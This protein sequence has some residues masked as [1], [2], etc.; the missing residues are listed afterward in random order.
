MDDGTTRGKCPTNPSN[1]FCHSNG[2]CNVCRLDTSSGVNVGCETLSSTPVCDADSTTTIVDD[3][4]LE[5][6]AACV[7]CKQDGKFYISTILDIP[8]HFIAHPANRNTGIL[9][10]S[11][12]VLDGITPGDGFSASKCSQYNCLSNGYCNVCGLLSGY[13]EG[14][15]IYSTTP[16][17]DGDNATPGIQELTTGTVAHCVSCTKSG[18][19]N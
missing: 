16:V 19:F 11:I 5:K 7:G 2:H 6:R 4:A 3:S 12:V 8:F 18:K 10:T 9:I 1:L 14:C 15:N 17:C 13:A